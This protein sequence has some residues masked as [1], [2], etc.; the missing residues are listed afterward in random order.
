MIEI[1]AEQLSEG[2]ADPYDSH[3]PLSQRLS[4]LSGNGASPIAGEDQSAVCLL[5]GLGQLEL[6]WL[7]FVSP[8]RGQ[9]LDL[10]EILRQ[11]R[12][13][14]IPREQWFELSHRLGIA[15]LIINTPEQKPAVTE[16]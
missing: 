2:K 15:N 11:L 6:R 7:E 12:T 9:K 8:E 3:P 5:P 14:S 4:A 1:S 13:F 10:F 16:V